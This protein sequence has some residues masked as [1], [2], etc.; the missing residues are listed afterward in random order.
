M[1]A[2]GPSIIPAL[3]RRRK[4]PRSTMRS[5]RNDA[6]KLKISLGLFFL[7]GISRRFFCLALRRISLGPA[8]GIVAAIWSW[9]LQKI[10]RPAGTWGAPDLVV[11]DNLLGAQLL[12]NPSEIPSPNL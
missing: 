2:N 7:L 11:G 6:S 12:P 4:P 5:R 1:K 3:R 10:G 8:K 9:Q